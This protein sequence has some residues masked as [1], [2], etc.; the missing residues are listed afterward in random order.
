MYVRPFHFEAPWT[1][2]VDSE[3]IVS[4]SWLIPSGTSAQDLFQQKIYFCHSNLLAKKKMGCGVIGKKIAEFEKK[5]IEL[6][7]RSITAE[8]K[9]EENQLRTELE[10]LLQVDVYWPFGNLCFSTK[11]L[12]DQKLYYSVGH[13]ILSVHGQLIHYLVGVRR[14]HVTS[15]ITVIYGANELGAR[16]DLWGTLGQI[17]TE[18][19]DELWLVLGDFNT[20]LDMSEV[21]GALGDTWTAMEEFQGCIEDTSLI[22]LPMR[23]ALFTWHNYSENEHSLWKRLDRMLMSDRWVAWWPTAHYLSLTPRTL[24]HSPLVLRE[25]LVSSH[26]M[27]L[28]VCGYAKIKSLKAGVPKSTSCERWRQSE[29]FS[30]FFKISDEEGRLHMDQS[31]VISEFVGYFQRYLGGERRKRFL[32]ITWTHHIISEMEAS[33]L[34]KPVSPLEVKEAV[35][36]I[37]EDKAPDP[38]GYLVGFYKAAWTIVGKEVTCAHVG[39]LQLKRTTSASE[40]DVTL[41]YPE[42][43]FAI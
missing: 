37:A 2:T 18:V 24:Y 25:G 9:N 22:S 29:Q 16:R 28:Y 15:L 38:D 11:R 43:S 8:N 21:N 13:E 30:I 14:V 26:Y 27:H 39:I 1:R 41:A 23:G 34:V 42:G 19:G 10:E 4:D 31:E 12:V 32:E 36:D 33:A 40:R 20:V 3:K 7:R 6:R 17:S 5:I 35:F